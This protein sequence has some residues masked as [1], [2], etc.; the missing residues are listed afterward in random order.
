V[1]IPEPDYSDSDDDDAVDDEIQL[2]LI[3]AKKLVNPCVESK[4]H[5]ALRREL[6]FNQK[7]YACPPAN[8]VFYY[9]RDATG[10][11]YGPVS[12]CLSVC[13]W[14][15]SRPTTDSGPSNSLNP[16]PVEASRGILS[17][18]MLPP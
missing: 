18:I 8:T 16:S 6:A 2:Q 17:F 14:L 12:V 11:G 10:T 1:D 4:E 15:T 7:L 5:Q 9:P 13:P 3:T